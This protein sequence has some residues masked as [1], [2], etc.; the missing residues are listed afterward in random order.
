MRISDVAAEAG[1]SPTTVSFVL[2]EKPGVAEATRARVLAAV[3]KL[4]Y[5]RNRF[6]RGLRAGGVPAIAIFIPDITNPYYSEVVLGVED[7]CRARGWD[8]MLYNMQLDPEREIAYLERAI[9]DDVEGLVYVPLTPLASSDERLR[10]HLSSGPPLVV[11]DEVESDTQGQFGIGAVTVE[12]ELG[13]RL[14]ARHFA[15]LGRR[16]AGVFGAPQGLPAAKLR[17]HG[18]VDECRALGIEVPEGA[19]QFWTPSVTDAVTRSVS[20][21]QDTSIDCFFAGNDALAIRVMHELQATGRR[22]PE[23]IAVC[24]F[25]DIEW[26]RFS[27][28]P[29]TTVE[30]P[31]RAIGAAAVDLISRARSEAGYQW[32]RIVLPVE[33]H[34]RAS[35]LGLPAAS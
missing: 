12:N 24:G 32:E 9:D 34:V 35:T 16:R 8:V 19:V 15:E 30:Q 28:P 13:G 5:R 10:R 26:S 33:L 23:D 25:D 22:V 18:F 21:L 14:V 20:M 3:D 2:Q 17:V 27:A 29:L 4:G 6:A 31:M 7:A 11:V 1:V